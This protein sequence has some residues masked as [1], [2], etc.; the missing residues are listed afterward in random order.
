MEEN[1]EAPARESVLKDFEADFSGR[2]EA[3]LARPMAAEELVDSVVPTIDEAVEVPD[4]EESLAAESTDDRW[5]EEPAAEEL[6]A[7]EPAVDEPAVDEPSEP[8][9]ELGSSSADAD[10]PDGGD[11]VAEDGPAESDALFSEESVDDYAAEPAEDWE[12]SVEPEAEAAPEVA[13]QSAAQAEGD[14]SGEQAVD[15][16]GGFEGDGEADDGKKKKKKRGRRRK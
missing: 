15:G 8:E 3:R 5:G 13:D 2:L 1:P 4:P 7:D 10:V 11:D 12:E 6:A 14:A 9:D 16:E